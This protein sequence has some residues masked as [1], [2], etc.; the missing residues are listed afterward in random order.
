LI[1]DNSEFFVNCFNIEKNNNN[2]NTKNYLKKDS[3]PEVSDGHEVDATIGHL[4]AT[5]PKVDTQVV[6]ITP[7]QNM[8]IQ[9]YHR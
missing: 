7:F 9:S 6:N 2:K 8:S 1:F 5:F 3:F 4:F